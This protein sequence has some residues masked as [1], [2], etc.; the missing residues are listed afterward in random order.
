MNRRGFLK[1][2][3]TALPA[4]SLTTDYV[5]PVDV[6]MG[7][8]SSKV[9]RPINL[10]DLTARVATML[11]EEFEGLLPAGVFRVDDPQRLGHSVLLPRRWIAVGREPRWP[12]PSAA[13]ETGLL[14]E[15]IHAVVQL[16]EGDEVE[17]ERKWLRPTVSTLA[18]MMRADN[19]RVTAPLAAPA[20]NPALGG[21]SYDVVV[22][23]RGG[24]FVRGL[25]R[26]DL[27]A[28]P[29]PAWETRFDVLY[30]GVPA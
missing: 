25:T 29:G 6:L 27:E 18:Q 12:L 23:E 19:V 3:G 7:T 10:Q 15:H 16:P 21:E 20:W 2:F 4:L 17:I 11:A 26:F 30:G 8:T 9:G 22:C 14:S 28:A 24:V 13:A 1:L 5:L